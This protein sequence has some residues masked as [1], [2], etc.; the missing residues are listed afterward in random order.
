MIEILLA[1]ESC[2][3]LINLANNNGETPAFAATIN[4]N[5]LCL[6]TLNR[7][8]GELG[9]MV[10]TGKSPILELMKKDKTIEFV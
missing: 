1:I 5:L 2:K 6:N 10:S 3:T 7:L 4:L 9:I 8:G